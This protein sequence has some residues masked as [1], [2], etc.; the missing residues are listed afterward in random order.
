MKKV[1]SILLGVALTSVAMAQTTP[2]AKAEGGKKQGEEQL[3]KAVEDKRADRKEMG[4][5]LTHLRISK[6]VKHR[7]E[8]RRHNKAIR[9]GSRHLRRHH[10]VKHPVMDAKKEIKEEEKKN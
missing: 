10:D 2:A 5:D 4:K 3:E 1:L 7:K 9:K 6:A 8:V